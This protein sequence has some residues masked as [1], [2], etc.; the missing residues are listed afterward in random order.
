MPSETAE[1]DPRAPVLIGVG[2]VADR[3]P[4]DVVG[5]DPIA[6]MA[7]AMRRADADAGGGWLGRVDD[8]AVVQQIGWP[9]L[10]PAAERLT[11]ALGVAPSRAVQSA[12]PHGDQPTRLL[13]DAAARI[14][15]GEAT[16]CAVVG[17]EALRSAKA[18]SARGG[19]ALSAGLQDELGRLSPDGI[20]LS[21][22][23]ALPT[24]VYP[25]YENA[26]RARLGQT[27]AEAQAETARLWSALSKVAA[28][29]E[30]AWLREPLPPE[31]IVTPGSRNP[32]ISHP[33][34][35]R[36]VAN[37]DVNQGAGCLL[38]SYGAARAAGLPRNALVFVGASTAA[39][40][41]D[42]ILAR[43]A[44][45]RS[46]SL[47][48]VL[49]ETLKRA[50][51][52]AGEIDH[53]ELYSCFPCVPKMALR[54][55]GWLLDRPITQYGGLTF[56]GG[57]IGNAMG[58]AVAGMV[59]RLRVSGGHG[60]IHANGGYMT[61]NH[62]VVLS[63]SAPCGDPGADPD[64]QARAD[65]LRGLVPPLDPEATGPARIETYTVGYGPDGRPS[66]GVVIARTEADA[67][68]LAR[69]PS[70]DPSLVA[71]L[72]DGRAEPIG[73]MGRVAPDRLWQTA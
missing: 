7:E 23:L 68:T 61:E 5:R 64:V 21:Y 71:A 57:P 66:G 58:H 12:L 44:Y 8:L 25:L 38:A 73:T 37:A 1:P 13:C 15:R 52:S 49:S 30:A 62:A 16:V 10:N 69:V 22:G 50:A 40:E 60:L 48:A 54:A 70:D 63:A 47:E 41:P 20:A 14:A 4:R 31:A 72:T 24:S 39:S 42:A 27:L 19:F 11:A 9:D 18:R 55:L 29:H 34:T 26:L 53:A 67:R 2:E 33:Y 3:T 28:T 65:A 32:P 36:Q 43:D 35:K 56:G 51:L 59:R 17:A 6:L 45:D 46:A